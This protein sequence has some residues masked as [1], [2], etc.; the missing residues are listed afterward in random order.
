MAAATDLNLRASAWYLAH[1]DQARRAWR[2]TLTILAGV[3]LAGGMVAGFFAWRGS[4]NVSVAQATRIS[5]PLLAAPAR[6]DLPKA[7]TVGT[8]RAI[9]TQ[10][11]RV[12]VVVEVANPNAH[13]AV[14]Q[15]R[16]RFIVGGQAQ[17]ERTVVLL[18]TS[19]RFLFEAN[20]AAG[21]NTLPGVEFEMLELAY[22]RPR[23]PRLL[24][25]VGFTLKE[26]RVD[27]SALAGSP[28]K[29]APRLTAT[30]ANVGVLGFRSVTLSIVLLAA[31]APVAVAERTVTDWLRDTGRSIEVQWLQTVGSNVE[32]V[33]VPQTDLF[34]A[35]NILR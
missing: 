23:D 21:G 22:G 11:G 33:I 2:I 26:Q 1:Q 17:P 27:L 34:D 5:A 16:Y 30:I 35:R 7:L 10:P 25:Q 9:L 12:D 14:R 8:P 32:A 15:L 4:R 18:P 6:N 29:P 13:Y 31:G 20:I 19:R 24:Q 28:A 3:F